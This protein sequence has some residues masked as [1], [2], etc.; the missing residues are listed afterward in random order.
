MKI[1]KNWIFAV[2]IILLI[3]IS[4]RDN[5]IPASGSESGTLTIASGNS[6]ATY[7]YIAAGQ[8]KILGEKLG[9]NIST[10]STSGSPVENL[11]LVSRDKNTLGLTTADGIQFAEQGSAERG[12]DKALGNLEVIQMG[13]VTYLYG[14]TLKEHQI[15]S[16]DQLKGKNVALPSAGSSTYYMALALLDFYG[17]SGNQVNLIPMASS[18][19]ADALKDGAIDFAFVPGGIPQATVT[20][21]D[22]SNDIVFLSI[23]PEVQEKLI[24]LYP[25][26][27]IGTIANHTYRGQAGEVSCMGVRTMLVCNSDLDEGLVYQIT[28]ALNESTDEMAQV[29]NSGSQWSLEVTREYLEDETLSFHEGAK[30][31][32]REVLQ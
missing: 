28:R 2:L 12:F 18:E 17:C 9:I 4:V 7:Y 26:W 1:D 27:E 13:H 20:D 6:G 14:L 32:Y 30:R 3:M 31:Y 25:W 29:H 15:A 8:S 5:Q 23:E 16:Y 11:T 21:L 10:Q 24:L 19:A 22:H